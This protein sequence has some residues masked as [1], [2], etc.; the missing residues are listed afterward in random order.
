[1]SRDR[2]PERVQR[3]RD[4][5]AA[6]DD[7][8]LAEELVDLAGANDDVWRHDGAT[9][10]TVVWRLS[11]ARRHALILD[12]ADRAPIH[13][14]VGL[15]GWLGYGLEADALSWRAGLILIEAASAR[16]TG[17]VDDLAVLAQV[18][19][20]E[21]GVVPPGLVAVMRRTQRWLGTDA[22]SLESWLASEQCLNAGEVWAEAANA[23]C[24]DSRLLALA[25]EVSTPQPK[26]KWS[27]RAVAL[28]EELGVPWCRKLIHRWCALVPAGRT[29]VLR[30]VA[31]EPDVNEALD[32]YNAQALRGLL[33]VL[34]VLPA[35]EED[36]P[37]AGALGEY[38][39][40]KVP[41]HGPR[42]QVVA[43]AAVHALESF[44]SVG[45]L[46]ELERLRALGPAR[47]VAG[48]LDAAIMRRRV[49]LR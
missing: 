13:T 16:P 15:L 8:R 45:A 18:A 26:I 27:R 10:R 41:G 5:A 37:V 21:T 48:R 46:R 28:V 39:A 32:P 47:G 23:E 34:S 11:P 2:Y 35:D 43:Y 31:D 44:G 20:R 30:R 7:R 36:V 3:V 25:L 38:A 9:V 33:F 49:A 12:A 22:T 1:M 19:M 14:L 4:L 42:S 6:G 29:I 17:F 40:Q 24:P